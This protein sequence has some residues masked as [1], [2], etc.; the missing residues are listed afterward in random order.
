MIGEGDMI[1]KKWRGVIIPGLI[2]II[3][4]FVLRLI[5]LTILP[6]FCDEAIYIRWSQ[7]MRAE[8]TLRFLPLSDGKQPLFMWLTI[9]F[10][11]FF[12]DPLLAGRL[13]SVLAGFGSLIGIFLLT[14]FL[15]ESKKTALFSS[16]IYTI[17]PYT[18][19]FD[20]MALVDSLLA[21]F[22]IW[23]LL[24]GVLLV[25]YPRTDLAIIGGIV[26]GGALITKS[27]AIFFAAL[28]PTTALLLPFEQPRKKLTPRLI[29]LAGLW[30]IVYIFAFV[31]Y[32]LLRLGPNFRMIAI[33]NK[34]YVFTLKE[35]MAHPHDPILIHLKD[36]WGWFPNL[37]SWPIFLMSI[38]GVVFGLAKRRKMSLVLLAWLLAPLLAQ[39]AFAKVFTPRYLLFTI[40][41]LIIFGGILGKEIFEK[42]SKIWLKAILILLFLFAPLRYDFSLISSPPEAPLPLRMRTGYLSEWTSGYGINEV[43]DFLKEA[44]KEKKIVVGTEGSFGT[45]PDALMIYFDKDSQVTILGVGLGLDKIPEPLKEAALTTPTYLVVN[46][47]RMLAQDDPG[48]KLIMK[49]AKQPGP[50]GQDHLLL[51]QL[52]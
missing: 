10:L 8:P 50:E 19:F 36:I 39:S 12:S 15:T 51:Y 43:R 3:L 40:F 27:P 46:Q 45:L 24:L 44:S 41:P 11:K 18:L 2:I 29:K 22:G 23:V 14:F 38:L 17:L 34:D 25:K 26:L 16:L 42:S 31:I 33:R 30:L 21:C 20:R 35:I 1:K 9:P 28:L 32:N 5:N 47:S 4:F 48:L 52:K 37:F 7:V 49:V 6:I 13:V